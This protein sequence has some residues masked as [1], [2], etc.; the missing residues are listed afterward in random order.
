[1]PGLLKRKYVGESMRLQKEYKGILDKIVSTLPYEY[2]KI[3][4]ID[5]YIKFYPN[6]WNKLKSRYD[7]Y[8]KKDNFLL[9][10][11]KKTRYNHK[12]PH[13]FF[14]SLPKVK[15]ILSDGFKKKHK[16][17]FSHEKMVA[18]VD[19][20]LLKKKPP[21][22][23][24]SKL[25][26]VDPAFLEYFILKY[27][28]KGTELDKK[29]E[30]V[31]ELKK[32]N[33]S[34]TV[35]FFQKLNDSENNNTIREIAF[36]HLQSI[37]AF[38]RKRKKFKGK[39]KAYQI[40]QCHFNGTP[41][42]LVKRIKEND[43]QAKKTFDIFISHSYKDNTLVSKIKNELNRYGLHIYCDWTSDND[44]L[45]RNSAS[46]FTEAVLKYRLECSHKVLFLQTDNSINSDATFPSTWVKMEID[47][48]KIS[49]KQILCLNLTNI[50]AISEIVN[51]T[52][53]SEFNFSIQP[54]EVNKL[55]ITKN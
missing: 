54:S 8:L 43:L 53:D 35:S 19:G 38:V 51:F 13:A 55:C 7:C 37:N 50:A 18:A 36:K 30:I 48:A 23:V 21:K 26:S 40:A 12:T 46:N 24:S 5:A 42:E 47:H 10:V 25:Q 9:S 33:T 22:E 2:E 3:D 27:H 49:S 16:M 52:I 32:Y 4:L 14:Y 34:N 17:N 11:N 39:V 1:M 45:K 6:H 31:N 29:I 44:F 15:L 28:K 20:L 41:E